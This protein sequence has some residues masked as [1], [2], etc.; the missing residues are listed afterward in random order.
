MKANKTY[1]QNE[2]TSPK[3]KLFKKKRKRKNLPKRKKQECQDK[4]NYKIT[5][6]KVGPEHLLNALYICE[7]C[8][9]CFCAHDC[10][11]HSNLNPNFIFLY[12]L[13]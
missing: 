5:Q 4:T 6:K 3:K 10:Y 1:T 8:K 11:V 7:V 2:K 9:W 12:S 13:T